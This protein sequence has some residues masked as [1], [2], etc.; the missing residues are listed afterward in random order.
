MS[1]IAFSTT[2]P[3]E[4]NG[5]NSIIGNLERLILRAKATDTS[6][7]HGEW[8]K[9]WKAVYDVMG[10]SEPTEIC[11]PNKQGGVYLDALIVAMG[12]TTTSAPITRDVYKL[13]GVNQ[14]FDMIDERRNGAFLLA[15]TFYATAGATQELTSHDTDPSYLQVSSTGD[16]LVQIGGSSL[17]T[18]P[19]SALG[20]ISTPKRIELGRADRNVRVRVDGVT[21]ASIANHGN[22]RFGIKHFGANQGLTAFSDG[23]FYDIQFT[24]QN[25]DHFYAADDLSSTLTDSGTAAM[26][27][28]I[29]NYNQANWV[30]V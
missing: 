23:A 5:D 13:D 14:Y 11:D 27:G 20:D 10:N 24:N 29:I 17:I 16:L 8:N 7:G 1:K 9:I 4:W 3:M 19:A 2:P 30:K 28:T 25:G 22:D 12:G 15:F 26:D 18:V 6:I 21:V